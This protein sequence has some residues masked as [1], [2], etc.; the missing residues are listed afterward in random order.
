MRTT[1]GL[2]C[3]QYGRVL[4]GTIGALGQD[5][6]FSNDGRFHAFSVNYEQEFAGLGCSDL[7]THGGAVFN[8]IV[9]KI[10][11]SAFLGSCYP[12]KPSFP[13]GF[14]APA[15]LEICPARDLRD[16]YFGLLGPDAVSISYKTAAGKLATERTAGLNGAYLIVGAPTSQACWSVDIDGRVVHPCGNGSTSRPDLQSYG[17][18]R[19]VTYRDRRTCR[20]AT[21]P[22]GCPP[23]GYNTTPV[24]HFT[25]SEVRTT[26]S[27]RTS[28]G[29]R[30]CT[31]G[32]T[33]QPCR[34]TPPPGYHLTPAF[35][36]AVNDDPPGGRPQIR[37]VVTFTSR[38]AITNI[39]SA[40]TFNW[41]LTPVPGEAS[42]RADCQIGDLDTTGN[43][44]HEDLR[45]G[46]RV[47]E[48]IFADQLCSGTM[49]G[50]VTL[51]TVT[52]PA[53]NLGV[54]GPQGRG[55]PVGD[56]SFRVP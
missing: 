52:G 20:P 22:S 49:H 27:V 53:T 24:Q 18:I 13:R 29:W 36:G 7:D 15:R 1:R 45:V 28:L 46:Q 47:T 48:D 56:F 38:V 44:T 9:Q 43:V 39:D 4:N 33:P 2:A 10:P 35:H 31:D 30:Y 55:I 5:G 51:N 6:A 14:P 8:A 40:Y 11:A 37:A 34:G 32:R 42:N 26:I 3:L 50:S 17:V 16:L 23:V 41:R 54:L 21:E 25:A 12:T 19:S